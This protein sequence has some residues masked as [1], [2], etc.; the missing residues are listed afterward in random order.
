[1]TKNVCMVCRIHESYCSCE[2]PSTPNKIFKHA[3]EIDQTKRKV[4]YTVD[5]NEY[6]R[7]YMAAKRRR[8]K[9]YGQKNNNQVQ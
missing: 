3:A 8:D 9:T 4:Y 5:R 7:L 6:A 2:S 1:M